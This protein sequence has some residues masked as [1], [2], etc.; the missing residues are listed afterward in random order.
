MVFQGA[1]IFNISPSSGI[2]L[3]DTITHID[4]TLLNSQGQL[5]NPM[6]YYNTYNQWIT[7][8]LYIGNTLYTVSNSEVQLNSL[9]D[10]S[11]IATIN[12]T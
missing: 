6:D 8:A 9:T 11:K 4:D 5:N 10:L 7:R 12:L 2:T 3:R 1:Y